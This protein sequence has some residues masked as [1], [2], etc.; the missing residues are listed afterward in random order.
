MIDEVKNFDMEIFLAFLEM[1]HSAEFVK[2]KDIIEN[3]KQHEELK[4][5][6]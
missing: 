6:V 2:V 4:L 3:N 1:V 5:I